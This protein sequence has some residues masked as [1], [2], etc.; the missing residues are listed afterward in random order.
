MRKIIAIVLAVMLM[1]S[2]AVSVQAVTPK[3]DTPSITIPDISDDIHIDLPDSA[4]EDYIPDI[5]ITIATEPE[6]PPE[7]IGCPGWCGVA[8]KWMAWWQNVIRTVKKGEMNH[9]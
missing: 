6:E 8:W 1:V 9:G 4:F 5:G 3:L 7:D 2:M